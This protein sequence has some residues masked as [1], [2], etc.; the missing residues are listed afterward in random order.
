MTFQRFLGFAAGL[1][2][3][4]AA[5]LSAQT[6]GSIVGRVIDESGAPLP[7]TTVEATSPSL[8]GAR[9]AVADANGDYRLTLLPPGSYTVSA[10]LQG[11]AP[12]RRTDVAVRLDQGTTLD[13][14][15][16]VTASDEITVTGEA[17]VIDSTST[18]LG[19]SL[20]IRAIQTL[21]TARNYSSVVQITPGVSSD[22]NPENQGQT[23]ISV[24][25][26]SGAENVFYID[27]VNTTGVEYGFQGKELNFE[28]IEA[29]DVKTG[30]YQAEFGRATGGV[31]N[32]VTKSGGN[33]FHGD[34]FGYLDNDSLQSSP[35][36]IVST[37]GTVEGFTRKDYGI[38]VGGFL[39][40]DKLWFFAAYDKVSNTLT[41]SLPDGPRS[42]QQVDSDS[43]RSSARA[44]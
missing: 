21:P 5:A 4:G 6:T 28:F 13:L 3:W 16:R 37:G 35:D 44:S 25:G 18:A 40:K 30:G 14:G 24:Y 26:S 19:T 38:G 1:T 42:G 23:T 11:F 36:P 9:T 32:V 41:S 8:Q 12:E 2:L 7:G 20:D 31:I 22:A 34:L 33:E 17:P 27:G 43:D 15:L 10:N 29:V 39:K